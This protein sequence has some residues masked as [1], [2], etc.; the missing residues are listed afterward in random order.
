[1]PAPDRWGE[2]F[3]DETVAAAMIDRLVHHAEVH[4]LKGDSY[5][6]RGRQL[7]R[8]PTATHDTD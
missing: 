6:M 7:G 1:M 4:S 8:V 3:G 2:V 5:R